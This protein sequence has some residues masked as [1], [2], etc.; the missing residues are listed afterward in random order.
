M[1][2]MISTRCIVYE[3]AIE[4]GTTKLYKHG[5]KFRH[6]NQTCNSLSVAPFLNALGAWVTSALGDVSIMR[7][8]CK[9]R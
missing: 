4:T 3:P 7:Q 5:V 1:T 2:T 9:S 8:V 6:S